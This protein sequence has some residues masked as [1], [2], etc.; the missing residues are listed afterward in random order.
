MTKGSR[1]RRRRLN[2]LAGFT[3]PVLCD[4]CGRVLRFTV[5]PTGLMVR[6]CPASCVQVPLGDSAE[7]TPT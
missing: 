4:R 7:S 3:G 5:E 2:R 1:Q 6:W